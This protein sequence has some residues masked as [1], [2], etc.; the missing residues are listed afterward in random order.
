MNWQEQLRTDGYAHFAGL[1]PERLVKSALNAIDHDLN[2]NYDSGRQ[3][4]YDNQSY[5]P[6]LRNT[7]PIMNLLTESPVLNVLD[8]LFGLEKIDWGNGQIAIRRA[9]NVPKAV[10]PE[11]HID[12]FSSGLNGLEEGRIYN[13]TVTVGVFLTPTTKEFAGNFTV[14]PGSHHLYERY[15]QE[16]GMRAFSEP[17][18]TL[19]IGQPVQLMCSVGDVVVAHYQ[20]AHSAAVNI[21]DSDRIA[22]FFRIW[23]RDVELRRWHYLTN[24]WEGWNL[25]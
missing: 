6:D 17:S 1:T 10:Q 19:E 3:V 11:P 16:R 15:F 20:L 21:S 4:E 9:H 24:I 12:G 5:C 23:L 18:P 2:S 7:P 22:I 14:W 8:E 13:H 25:P